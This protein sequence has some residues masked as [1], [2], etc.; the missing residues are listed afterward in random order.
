MSLMPEPQPKSKL[1]PASSLP[2]TLGFLLKAEW[3]HLADMEPVRLCLLLLPSM[4][5]LPISPLLPIAAY[6]LW[7]WAAHSWAWRDRWTSIWAWAKQGGAFVALVLVIVL[8]SSARVWI[9]PELTAALQA[10]WRAHLGGNLSLWPSDP[11]GLF[12]RTFLLLPLAPVL[13]LL[14]EWL[15]P[16][17][18]IQPQRILT[19]TDLV[20]PKPS[21]KASPTASSMAQEELPLLSQVRTHAAK[22]RPVPTPTAQRKQT[23]KG[24]PTGQTT[25]SM[26][27]RR[28]SSTC[29]P[30][31]KKKP[32][33]P[34][35]A[36]ETHPS[37]SPPI[38]WND[39]AE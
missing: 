25:E 8:L 27:P 11:D 26:T 19:P 34:K 31:Q 18:C 5:L 28:L 23:K 22:A 37:A 6:A 7:L 13:A 29:E 20:E 2:P 33:S 21:P 14:Y 16:R 32:M 36:T 3:Q 9:L 38:D 1:G 24:E 4:L 35:P 15:D 17:T 39:V 10:Y 12:T 30:S